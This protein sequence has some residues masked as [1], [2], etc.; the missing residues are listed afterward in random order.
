MLDLNQHL[1]DSGIGWTLKAAYDINDNGW[2]VGV[3]INPQGQYQSFLLV[4]VPEPNAIV[5]LG[6]GLATLSMA[7]L[8]RRRSISRRAS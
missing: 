7:G 8:V 2:I 6:T 1:N 3:G 4:P 5:L